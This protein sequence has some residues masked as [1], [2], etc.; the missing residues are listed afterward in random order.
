VPPFLAQGHRVEVV[1]LDDPQAGYLAADNFTI[2]ALG[3]GRGVWNF[4][5]ALLPWLKAH[6][7]DYDAVILNGLW[8]YQCYAV[9]KAAQATKLPY[10]VFPHGMLDPWFQKLSV[11]P[12]K[13]IRNWMAWKLVEHRVVNHASAL[14]FTCEE[15]RRL[16]RLPFRPYRPKREIV[17]GLGLP[18]PPPCQPAM[19][20]A[21]AEKCPALNGHPY[22][23]FLGRIHE[24][25]GVDALIQAY[26]ALGRRDETAPLPK[27]VIAGPDLHLPYGQ[28]MRRLATETC[29]EH[30]VFWPGMLAGDAKWGALYHCDVSV[31]PSH[32]ENFGISV[33]E[34]LACGRPVL[35]SDQVNIW[36]EIQA[37]GAALV[38]PDSV[39]GARAL[40]TD[41]FRLPPGTR[42]TM[43]A[44]AKTCF[45]NC[46]SLQSATQKLLANLTH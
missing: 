13:T 18:E 27:L 8:Q 24:K 43:A 17:V 44:R 9:W 16:A 28:K 33:V 36:R 1:C 31:L 21:F 12:L 20:A 3:R 41:W 34:T 39:A 35:I 26:A 30:S 23:L 4:N 45:E 32:Q 25:K 19:Q 2:H 42:S 11:R 38:Q 7:A 22:L 5:P 10:Y 29:P 40:L 15:E 14:L 37:A 6:Q 46:F